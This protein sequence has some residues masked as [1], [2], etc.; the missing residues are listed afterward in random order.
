MLFFTADTVKNVYSTP[1]NSISL[2]SYP[3]SH[4]TVSPNFIY[5]FEAHVIFLTFT[6][7]LYTL[8]LF[9]RILN[10]SIR[11][12][13]SNQVSIVFLGFSSRSGDL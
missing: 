5:E 1:H 9:S 3:Y 11:M 10:C 7:V 2:P 8:V 12:L 6:L 13:F 4:T